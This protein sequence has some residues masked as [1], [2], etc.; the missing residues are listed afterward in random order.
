MND[1]LKQILIILV[2]IAVVI[3][4]AYLIDFE[5]VIEILRSADKA[6]LA[7]SALAMVVG[8]I[9]VSVRLR[10]IL[11]KRV[12]WK[13]TFY[14]DALGFM[15]TP[16]LPLPTPVLR[17]IGVERT[18][19]LNASTV[20]PALAVDYL[21][22]MVMRVF[23]LIF[24]IFLTPSAI[25]SSWSV[26]GSILM[27]IVLFGGLI[28]LVNHLDQTFDAISRW[29]SLMPRI[30]EERVRG[31]LTE[32]QEALEAAG[33][34]RSLLLSLFY[35]L[36]IMLC[37]ALYHYLVWAAFPLDLTWRKM[38]ALSLAALVVVPPTAPLMI[39]AYQGLLVGTLAVFRVLDASTLMAYAILVQAMQII[40]WIIIGVWV[41]FRTKISL[42]DFVRSSRRTADS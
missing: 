40:F 34:T 28:W 26:V 4:L 31:T 8:F 16:F 30:D 7:L 24:V 17:G 23:A 6:L 20:S 12:G 1:R 2:V 32:V 39:G 22:G 10:D 33:S 5:E 14:G 13:R 11:G 9:L 19:P 27:V 36:V 41:L 37:F 29:L 42:T 38:L 35:T 15:T 25:D 21:L 3:V 18:T